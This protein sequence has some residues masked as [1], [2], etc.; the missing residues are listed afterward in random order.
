MTE[1]PR[2][3]LERE[4]SALDQLLA[5]PDLDNTILECIGS[6]PVWRRYQPRLPRRRMR[7]SKPMQVIRHPSHP[8]GNRPC[9]VCG[10]P[11]STAAEVL[12]QL[13]EG[14]GRS[15]LWPCCADHPDEQVQ[16]TIVQRAL[17]QP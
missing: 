3:M 15:P 2:Q 9:V 10:S 13:P 8:R 1:S 14:R 5:D 4:R 17:D 7:R 6:R 16:E 12:M 11:A